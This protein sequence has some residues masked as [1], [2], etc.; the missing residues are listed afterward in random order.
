MHQ[1]KHTLT[2]SH[3]EKCV[4]TYIC[5][6]RCRFTQLHTRFDSSDCGFTFK[7]MCTK[8]VAFNDLDSLCVSEEGKEKK[9]KRVHL[10][11]L[12]GAASLCVYAHVTLLT[13][14][15]ESRCMTC[16]CTFVSLGLAPM[17][18]HR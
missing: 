2:V 1:H 18:K 15:R 11:E 17:M 8:S 7:L 9:K 5:T 14:L 3:T 4:C 10:C 13:L 16:Q 12:H 6:F